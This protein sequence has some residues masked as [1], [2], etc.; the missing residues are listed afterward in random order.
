[1]IHVQY[2][3]F[4]ELNGG[5]HQTIYKVLPVDIQHPLYIEL[6]YFIFRVRLKKKSPKMP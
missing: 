4:T 2:S 3:C 5:L 6:I 1:M